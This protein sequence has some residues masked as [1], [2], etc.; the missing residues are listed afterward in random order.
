MHHGA[1]MV[2]LTMLPHLAMHLGIRAV[3]GTDLVCLHVCLFARAA[4]RPAVV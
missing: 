1:C 3:D 4:M 2:R